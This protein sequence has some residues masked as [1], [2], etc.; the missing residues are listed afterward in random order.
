MARPYFNLSTAELNRI[1]LQARDDEAV[2][3]TILDE[4]ENRDRLKALDLKQRVKSQLDSKQLLASSPR[5]EPPPPAPKTSGLRSVIFAVALI[6][7]ALVGVLFVSVWPD[8]DTQKQAGPSTAFDDADA[9]LLV[10]QAANAAAEMVR[11]VEAL[12]KALEAERQR[13][14]QTDSER[15]LNQA[16]TNALEQELQSA[17]V[18]QREQNAALKAAQD[19]RERGLAA[20]IEQRRPGGDRRPQS[21]LKPYTD[22]ELGWWSRNMP[23][24]LGGDDTARPLEEADAAYSKG[25]YAT[26]LRIWQPLAAQGNA[27]AQFHL[28]VMYRNGRGVQQDYMQAH[29]WFSLAAAKGHASAIESRDFV[30]ARMAVAQQLVDAVAAY[31]KG[32][33]ATALRIWRPLAEQGDAEAQ[34]RLA[35]MYV[36]GSGVAQDS[37]AAVSWYRMAAE[38]G[39]A[40]AQIN[41]GLRYTRGLGVPKDYVQA[42]MWHSLAAAQEDSDAA[43]YRDAVAAHMTALQIAEA[44]RLAR[45]WRPKPAR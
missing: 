18:R 5:G 40:S 27:R 6:A 43:K 9:Q 3:H 1:F 29:R 45:E 13:V 15:D 42:H 37:A 33:Y 36:F 34:F 23:T 26:A 44:Q 38:Q 19:A 2:L 8:S 39:K 31:N 22:V 41:L 10:R 20:A 30:A 32:D 25:D 11:K 35:G 4:L 28:G 7:L 24:W 16:A 14:V 17:E 21:E 12:R